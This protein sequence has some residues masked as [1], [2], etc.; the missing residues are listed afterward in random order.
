MKK[1]QKAKP[2]QSKLAAQN[3][4]VSR[5]ITAMAI[6]SKALQAAEDA[7]VN[8][9]GELSLQVEQRLSIHGRMT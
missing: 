1:K 6:L 7:G 2:K 9:G 8:I 4:A 5:V 3:L